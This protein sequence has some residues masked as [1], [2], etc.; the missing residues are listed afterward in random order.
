MASSS[1]SVRGWEQAGKESVPLLV[2]WDPQQ[3]TAFS[4]VVA[5][6]AF[7][8]TSATAASVASAAFVAFAASVAFAA[9][10]EQSFYVVEPL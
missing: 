1:I 8:E 5:I 10:A 7:V 2:Q 6:A 3:V 4:E 9:V